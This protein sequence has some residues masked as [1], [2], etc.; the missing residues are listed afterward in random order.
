MKQLNS[1]VW[2][3]AFLSLG[4]VLIIALSIFIAIKY[5]IGADQ[6]KSTKY[7][8]NIT[9]LGLNQ[10]TQTKITQSGTEYRIRYI[11]QAGKSLTYLIDVNDPE[12]K[13]GGYLKI[14]LE[15]P[16]RSVE[17]LIEPKPYFRDSSA[18]ILKGADASYKS[19]LASHKSTGSSVELE[20]DDRLSSDDATARLRT[21][22]ITPKG[23]SL[24]ISTKSND[25]DNPPAALNANYAGLSIGADSLKSDARTINI[26][27]M[28]NIPI[29]LKD[30]V[31]ASAYIDPTDSN[32]T[33]MLEENPQNLSNIQ[34]SINYKYNKTKFAAYPSSSLYEETTPG[35]TN[36]LYETL[37]LTASDEISDLFANAQNQ[38]TSY[39]N[40]ISKFAFTNYWVIGN[41][42]DNLDSTQEKLP[43]NLGEFGKAG[44]KL[45]NLKEFQYQQAYLKILKGYSLDDLFVKSHAWQKNPRVDLPPE[46]FPIEPNY[47]TEQQYKAMIKQSKDMGFVFT[48][49]QFWTY[50]NDTSPL[51]NLLSGYI[52]TKSN[53]EPKKKTDFGKTLS[54]TAYIKAAERQNPQS[55]ISQI[56]ELTNLGISG[57]FL[58][59]QAA[60]A[61]YRLGE[62]SARDPNASS[63]KQTISLNKRFFEYLKTHY[64][65]AL[66]GEGGKGVDRFD[67]YY[68]GYMDSIERE[69]DDPYGAV[70]PDF[71]LSVIKAK[72]IGS[73]MGQ[74]SRW[75]CRGKNIEND[76]T[77]SLSGE[78]ECGEGFADYNWDRYRAQTIS[79]G[80]AASLKG[81]THPAVRKKLDLEGKKLDNF[82]N[83]IRYLIKEYFLT[84]TLQKLY[85]DSPIKS[86]EY[87]DKSSL[88]GNLSQVQTKK[89]NYSFLAS[90]IKL[91]Y[92]NG[93]IIHINNSQQSNWEI[94]PQ[95]KKILPPNGF[96]AEN[97]F[98]PGWQKKGFFQA[99]FVLEN[100]NPVYFS[101]SEDY[102]FSQIK[103]NLYVAKKDGKKISCNGGNI[104]QTGLIPADTAS[105][106]K[107]PVPA[108]SQTPASVSSSQSSSTANDSSTVRQDLISP[109]QFSVRDLGKKASPSGTSKYVSASA[110]RSGIPAIAY[111]IF[112]GSAI[113]IVL[114]GVYRAKKRNQQQ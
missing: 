101:Q 51:K 49:H 88:I 13:D 52:S 75:A 65:G 62:V 82:K 66:T 6:I 111:I 48:N 55:A 74:V 57:A 81:P 26:P 45:A 41:F 39:R 11:D 89:P 98:M 44:G 9:P 84:H 36:P 8:E 110:I 24:K 83:E 3:K 47:G 63:L 77:N 14:S 17:P 54:P 91:T 22:S 108:S 5:K 31:F 99:G 96:Y 59:T 28:P 90:Q 34:N 10:K 16:D 43:F 103:G 12:I 85:I 86:I 35:K 19:T 60:Y 33:F 114:L 46:Q 23:K 20:F 113:V 80:H 18:K 76:P 109:N 53:G 21:V 104:C 37:Y 102:T 42:M 79:Y 67:T 30:G 112:S 58:D 107:T 15:K 94:A 100:N 64:R 25:I 105:P 69:A 61:P 87:Y 70:I 93:T 73:G 95:E 1:G 40:S 56:A 106:T 68:A 38:A 29:F 7:N 27:Y 72:M 50:L 78:N 97:K 71:E 32:G 4:A 92:S 2:R